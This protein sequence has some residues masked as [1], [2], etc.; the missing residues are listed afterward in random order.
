MK[1]T[2]TISCFAI[3]YLLCSSLHLNGQPLKRPSA[4]YLSLSFVGAGLTHPGFAVN[5]AFVLKEWNRGKSKP[6]GKTKIKYYEFLLE[7]RLAFYNHK[8]NHSGILFNSGLGFERSNEKNFY[9]QIGGF[10]G[11][12][13]SILNEDVYRVSATG[14][15]QQLKFASNIGFAVGCRTKFGKKV[16]FLDERQKLS[17]F[18]GSNFIYTTPFSTSGLLL[19]IVELGVNYKI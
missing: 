16:S 7:N 4:Q 15:V 11:G 3:L 18:L 12:L 13:W 9:W 2:I 10:V 1:L 6:N 5:H 17:Y 14:T 19:N 8:R